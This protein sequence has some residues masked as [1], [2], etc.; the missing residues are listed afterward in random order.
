MKIQ[1]VCVKL[2]SGKNYHYAYIIG[3]TPDEVFE[4][5][6]QRFGHSFSS[7]RPTKKYLSELKENGSKTQKE[8][9]AKAAQS[10]EINESAS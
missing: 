6:S 9:I 7:E 8:V 10:S 4:S 1:Y 3:K 5:M 2:Y